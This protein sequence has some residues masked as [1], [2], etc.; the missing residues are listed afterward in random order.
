MGESEIEGF[1]NVEEDGSFWATFYDPMPGGSGFLPQILR[2]W[3][4]IIDSAIVSLKDCDCEAACYKCML[5]FR[6]QHYHEYLNRNS[7]ISLLSEISADIEKEV[8]IPV[9]TIKKNVEKWKTDSDAELQLLDLIEQFG[10]PNP[11]DLQYEITI[12]REKISADFAYAEEDKTKTVLIFVDGMS[13]TLHGNPNQ[14]RKDNLNR[15]RLKMEGYKVIVTSAVG[16]R[17]K[18]NLINFFNE[19]ASYLG[20]QDLIQE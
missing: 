13:K 14:I 18:T 2:N 17:D 15:V 20:R 19:L 5:H 3:R 12:G 8:N 10:F 4:L 11:T 16:L 7:A 9:I 6:N 1:V